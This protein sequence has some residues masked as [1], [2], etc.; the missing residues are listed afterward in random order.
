MLPRVLLCAALIL[1]QPQTTASRKSRR[2]GGSGSSR[3]ADS[4]LTA[5]KAHFEENRLAE[6]LHSFSNAVEASPRHPKAGR[7][8]AIA[9]ERMGRFDEALISFDAAL[10]ANA[11]S[12]DVAFLKGRLLQRMQ[13]YGE[14]TTW[15]RHAVK[16]M[17]SGSSELHA[18][19]CSTLHLVGKPG[20]QFA[21]K[22]GHNHGLLQ[23]AVASCDIAIA[24][25]ASTPTAAATRIRC[26]KSKSH[27]LSFL[28]K[29]LSVC[30]CA[31]FRTDLELC[32]PGR[33]AE[34]RIA[35]AQA[36]D[37]TSNHRPLSQQLDEASNMFL[38]P[39]DDR[40]PPQQS[41][42]HMLWSDSA[43]ATPT[44]EALWVSGFGTP[45]WISESDNA[46]L[47]Q[48]LEVVVQQMLV[49]DPDGVKKSNFG[50]WQSSSGDSR[51]SALYNHAPISR[52]QSC[53]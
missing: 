28:G 2:G 16:V 47:N 39:T 49:K 31:V 10:A 11:D 20:G 29:L 5:G 46:T 14:A 19:L 43:S 23:E 1:S 17:P 15:L 50:G 32:H 8:K 27:S 36:L 42:L 24:A 9:Q 33:H 3:A 30:P 35:S 45:V 7:L 41:N 6:A 18:A 38:A 52:I 48:E 21:P 13:R 44:T 26:L 53:C 34:A 25:P 37:A 22:V 51:V 12:G 40:L 4:L